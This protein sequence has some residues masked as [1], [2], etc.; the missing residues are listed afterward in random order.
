V[1]RTIARAPHAAEPI[2]NLTIG[3]D[4]GTDG[5]LV[6]LPPG[7][8]TVSARVLGDVTPAVD[9]AL[10]GYRGADPAATIEGTLGKRSRSFRV[11][12]AGGT[13]MYSLRNMAPVAMDASLAAITNH[14]QWVHLKMTLVRDESSADPPRFTG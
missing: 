13:Y 10:V 6:E 11:R 14:R 4:P 8:L 3:V 9:F 7:D 1:A 5:H 12:I 2:I